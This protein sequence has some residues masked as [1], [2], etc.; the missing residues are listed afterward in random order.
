MSSQCGPC[1]SC[2]CPV[3]W[4]V[5]QPYVPSVASVASVVSAAPDCLSGHTP[6]GPRFAIAPPT[7]HRHAPACPVHRAIPV[8]AGCA[9]PATSGALASLGSCRSAAARARRREPPTPRVHGDGSVHGAYWGMAVSGE[10]P[11]ANRGRIGVWPLGQSGAALTA[12]A[13]LAIL[14]TYG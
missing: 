2:V 6:M 3:W 11:M 14:G 10:G 5:C 9:R 12:L 7:A 1:P 4:V 13:T 8:H